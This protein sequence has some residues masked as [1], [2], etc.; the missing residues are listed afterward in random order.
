MKS[1]YYGEIISDGSIKDEDGELVKHLK[2]LYTRYNPSWKITEEAYAMLD[3]I[4]IDLDIEIERQLKLAK[5]ILN[6]IDSEYATVINSNKV[7]NSSDTI[8]ESIVN[9][10]DFKGWLAKIEKRQ[11]KEEPFPENEVFKRKTLNMLLC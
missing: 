8:G 11:T 4:M 9:D 7:A 5:Y 2:E 10:P 6:K 3:L 1:R